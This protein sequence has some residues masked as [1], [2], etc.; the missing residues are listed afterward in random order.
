[1]LLL[2]VI[3]TIMHQENP[4]LYTNKLLDLLSGFSILIDYKGKIQKSIEFIYTRNK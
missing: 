4:K 1:M 3:E 2:F